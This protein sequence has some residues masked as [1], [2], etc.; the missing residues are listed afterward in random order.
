MNNKMA[1][2]Y[3]LTKTA[4]ETLETQFYF[5]NILIENYLCG[6]IKPN[7]IIPY[8]KYLKQAQIKSC[9]KIDI[10]K[11]LLFTIKN[12][13]YYLTSDIDKINEFALKYFSLLILPFKCKETN[14]IQ[15]AF[16]NY[17]KKKFLNLPNRLHFHPSDAEKDI[18]TSEKCTDHNNKSHCF[19]LSEQEKKVLGLRLHIYFKTEKQREKNINSLLSDIIYEKV[20]IKEDVTKYL[21]LGLGDLS[22][23]GCKLTLL[24][25]DYEEFI[26][27]DDKGCFINADLNTNKPLLCGALLTAIS[28]MF[29]DEDAAIVFAINVTSDN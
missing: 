27:Q 8:K 16:F 6:L 12:E 11:N 26:R 9:Y 21:E 28:K 23:L 22:K 13:R 29:V 15:T 4:V 7:K 25:D 5:T 20:N 14:L 1:I 3:E 17:C 10:R 18:K 24:Y 19:E 2:I